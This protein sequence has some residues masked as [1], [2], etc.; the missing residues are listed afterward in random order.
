MNHLS[1]R[2][3]VDGSKADPIPRGSLLIIIGFLNDRI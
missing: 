3:D 1:Q 2:R